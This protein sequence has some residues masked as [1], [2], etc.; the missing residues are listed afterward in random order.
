[1][2]APRR[3]SAA[4]AA[5]SA[6]PEL[7]GRTYGIPFEDVWQA[8]LHLAERR[9]RGWSVR[10]ADDQVGIIRAETRS[11]FGSEHDVTISVT[12]DPNAQTRVDATAAARKP[13]WDLGAARRRLIRFYRALD[14]TLARSPRARALRRA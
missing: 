5:R 7:R 2:S 6:D 4:T 8:C 1:V 9:L 3:G 10:E 12:L 11:L 14:R 13:D